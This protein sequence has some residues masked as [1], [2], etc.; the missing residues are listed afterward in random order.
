MV[1][2]L[3]IMFLKWLFFE[4]MKMI[5]NLIL[6]LLF[7][8]CSPAPAPT[9]DVINSPTTNPNTVSPSSTT[10]GTSTETSTGS[11]SATSSETG[12]GSSTGSS[13]ETGTG[14]ST[15]STTVGESGA[16]TSVAVGLISGGSS[17]ANQN[18]D[19]EDED[20]D[21]DGD[22][23]DDDKD[24]YQTIGQG[25]ELTVTV[26]TTNGA[27]IVLSSLPGNTQ[28]ETINNGGNFFVSNPKENSC[29][30]R[31]SRSNAEYKITRVSLSSASSELRFDKICSSSGFNF[32]AE[33]YLKV[34]VF[35]S[36]S[37]T[38]DI[39]VQLSN[40]DQPHTLSRTQNGNGN[41][42]LNTCSNETKCYTNSSLTLF[43]KTQNKFEFTIQRNSGFSD[44]KIWFKVIKSSEIN[45]FY[46]NHY[47]SKIIA[48]FP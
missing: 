3:E 41:L 44:S 8:S 31:I 15:G 42:F 11:S 26:P 36:P 43:R 18:D 21:E 5:K 20:D 39:G 35:S 46:K 37:T 9:R 40:E 28:P 2:D 24:Q 4:G 23:K 45:G 17:Q 7:I 30:F 25:T 27:E 16:G 33:K 12:T 32:C 29:Y 1:P 47:L 10:S 48:P 38:C 34:E 19:D 22:D 6:T 13:S 14:S